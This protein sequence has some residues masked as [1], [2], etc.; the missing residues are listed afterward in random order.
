MSTRGALPPIPPDVTKQLADTR[1]ARELLVEQMQYRRLHRLK[2]R[3][4]ATYDW[5]TPYVD[6]IDRARRDPAFAGPAGAW[7][8]RYGRNYPIYQT[9]QELGT[10]RAGAR[11]LL[12]TN[13]TRSGSRRG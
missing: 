12:A 9:E 8:R 6:L 7:M 1:A 5:V 11:V 2:E 3:Q 10:Y 4:E 13:S